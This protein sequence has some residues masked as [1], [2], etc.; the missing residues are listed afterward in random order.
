MPCG[1]GERGL[2]PAVGGSPVSPLPAGLG[3]LLQCCLCACSCWLAGEGLGFYDLNTNLCFPQKDTLP[4]EGQ[5]LV[6]ETHLPLRVTVLGAC[7]LAG[8]PPPRLFCC[9]RCITEPLIFT[10]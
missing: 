4:N 9:L 3:A 5:G 7:E 10:F 2:C 6:E 1:L 8:L